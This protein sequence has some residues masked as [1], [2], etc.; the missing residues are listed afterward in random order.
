MGATVQAYLRKHVG[1]HSTKPVTDLMAILWGKV[2]QVMLFTLLGASMDQS[3]LDP[4]IV[5]LGFFTV[6]IGLVGRSI[7]CFCSCAPLRSWNKKE[8]GFAWSRGA[9][10]RLCRPRL[11]R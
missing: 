7:A 11:P 8:K 2:G 5:V 10:R 6:I 1:E 3:K 9:Q 4:E